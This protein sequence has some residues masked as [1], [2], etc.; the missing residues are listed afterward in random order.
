[1]ILM[2]YGPL[3]KRV[4]RNICGFFFCPSKLKFGLVVPSRCVLTSV[5]FSM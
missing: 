2:P 3:A 1:M 4:V 5:K